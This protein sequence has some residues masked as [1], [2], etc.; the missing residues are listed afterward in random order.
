MPFLNGL[1]RCNDKVVFDSLNAIGRIQ[2]EPAAKLP[3]DPDPLPTSEYCP[4]FV[5][6]I[7][8]RRNVIVLRCPM[9]SFLIAGRNTE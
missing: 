6:R 4:S 1:L 9:A 7:Y 8:T 3:S 2:I 5:V